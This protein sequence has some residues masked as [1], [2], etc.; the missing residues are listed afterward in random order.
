MMVIVECFKDQQLMFKMGF[1]R[2][3]MGHEKGRSKVLA[4]LEQERQAIG[5]IDEDPQ[6]GQPPDLRKYEQKK[7]FGKISLLIGEDDDGKEVIRRAIRISPRL[8]DWLYTIAARNKVSPE[9]FGL[10]SNPRELHKRSLK[11]D[12]DFRRFL[13][14]LIKKKDE[15]IST[16]TKWIWEAIAE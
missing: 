6:A 5:I 7:T 8:E 13:E 9:T 3:Q 2:D 16:M 4:K 11:G 1:I 10:P 12:K 15:E 14:E